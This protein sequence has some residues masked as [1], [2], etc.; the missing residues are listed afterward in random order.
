MEESFT[1]KVKNFFRIK[2]PSGYTYDEIGVPLAEGMINGLNESLAALSGS[3][4][5]Q[6]IADAFGLIKTS[7]IAA[8][9]EQSI[10]LLELTNASIGALTEAYNLYYQTYIETY[11]AFNETVYA[12]ASG[13]ADALISLYERFNSTAITLLESLRD[14]A[15]AVF[16]QMQTRLTATA[17]ATVD[18]VVAEF[19]KLAARIISELNNVVNQVNSA[20]QKK[21]FFNAGRSLGDQFIDGLVEE[22]RKDSQVRRVEKAANALINT[23][24]A[25]NTQTPAASVQAASVVGQRADINRGRRIVTPSPA[26]KSTTPNV[27]IDVSKIVGAITNLSRA[28]YYEGQR[29]KAAVDSLVTTIQNSTI[30]IVEAI[31]TMVIATPSGATATLPISNPVGGTVGTTTIPS[32]GST[33][34]N[35]ITNN[36]TLNQTVT[37]DIAGNAAESFE[38]MQ[39][40]IG[41]GNAGGLA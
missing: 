3:E 21:D 24:N 30:A 10:S 29:Q 19:K 6:S 22:L 8:T 31:G 34:I 1:D 32:A 25:P 36:F 2:S 13:Q 40:L 12:M 5:V 17:R 27:T 14:R 38:V 23:R 7:T 20:D 9:D 41:P 35:N 18:A 26:A 11:S 28:F 16:A 4:F 37:P 39:S 15:A 33:I